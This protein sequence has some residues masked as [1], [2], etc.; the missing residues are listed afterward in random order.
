MLT[1]LAVGDAKRGTW[2]QDAFDDIETYDN[3]VFRVEASVRDHLNVR[4][5]KFNDDFR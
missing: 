2:L 3:R 1:Y 4:K 5:N